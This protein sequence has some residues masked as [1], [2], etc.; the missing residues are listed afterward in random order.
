MYLLLFLSARASYDAKD[1]AEAFVLL[2]KRHLALRTWHATPASTEPT[3]GYARTRPRCLKWPL[4]MSFVACGPGKTCMCALRRPLLGPHLRKTTPRPNGL[5]RP[6][7]PRGVT[8]RLKGG[9]REYKSF[10]TRPPPR[11]SWC[12][13][14]LVPEA[15]E[16]AQARLALSF[17]PQPLPRVCILALSVSDAKK[18][19]R[20]PLSR[21][22]NQ[23]AGRGRESLYPAP[24]AL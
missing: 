22:T 15:K 4:C 10:T 20:G 3:S 8:C 19:P 2:S 21:G 14:G 5:G 6:P 11:A 7:M 12:L 16:R 9:I 1:T 13:G 18:R 24:H 17:A 23:D